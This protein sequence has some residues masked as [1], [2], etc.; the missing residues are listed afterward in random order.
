MMVKGSGGLEGVTQEKEHMPSMYEASSPQS[1]TPGCAFFN[2][3][4]RER[5]NDLFFF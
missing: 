3:R 2:K 5:I 4:L 1:S